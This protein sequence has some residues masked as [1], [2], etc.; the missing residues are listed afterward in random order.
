MKVLFLC[1]SRGIGHL[2]RSLELARY[3]R[4][5][6]VDVIFACG[7]GKWRKL[8]RFYS[9]HPEQLHEPV[10]RR[11]LLFGIGTPSSDELLKAFESEVT[12]IK[13]HKPTAVIADW[14]PTANTSAK[15]FETPCIQIWNSNWGLFANSDLLVRRELRPFYRRILQYWLAEFLK[16]FDRIGHPEK[17]DI[18]NIFHGQLNLVPD[19]TEFR[20]ATKP[21]RNGIWLGPLIPWLPSNSIVRTSSNDVAVTFGGHEPPGYSER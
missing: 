9:F 2:A 1:G 21:I 20:G 8:T 5:N 12:L 4:S 6:G 10:L 19:D 17:Q 18:N 14:R 11:P 13:R 3:L 15:A 16:F 7:A